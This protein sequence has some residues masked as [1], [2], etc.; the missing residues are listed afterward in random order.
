M[1]K[2]RVGGIL[3]I[4]MGMSVFAQNDVMDTIFQPSKNQDFVINIGNSKN[5]VGNEVFR[6]SS[7]LEASMGMVEACFQYSPSFGKDDC[8]GSGMKWDGKCYLLP[9]KNLDKSACA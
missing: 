4:V 8:K 3:V 5:A 7:S 2:W 1:K 6:G 9:E